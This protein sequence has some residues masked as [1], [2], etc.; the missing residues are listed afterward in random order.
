[1]EKAIEEKLE[2]YFI[3]LKGVVTNGILNINPISYI[4]NRIKKGFKTEDREPRTENREPRTE[5]RESRI[6]HHRHTHMK[7]VKDSK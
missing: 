7:R 3:I 2:K 4:C 1:M 6:L 5:N